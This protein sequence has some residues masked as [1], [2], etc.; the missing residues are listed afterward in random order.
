M[1]VE[2]DARQRQQ[3][4]DQPRH[5]RRLALHD[6]KEF[7]ARDRI[8]LRRALQ[9]FDEAEQRGQRRAQ[10]VAGIGDEVGAHFLDPAQRRQI[11]EG[12]HQNIGVIAGETHRRD[13]SLEPAVERHTLEEFD[14]LG[15]AGLAGAPDRV[16]QFRH[17]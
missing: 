9:G 14:T 10:F 3:I 4:V 17:A 1:R 2:F 5:A 8:V 15:F 6:T 13:K 7:F 11:V 16:D 12:H